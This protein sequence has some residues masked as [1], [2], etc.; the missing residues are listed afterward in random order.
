MYGLGHPNEDVAR[1]CPYPSVPRECL[2]KGS[3]LLRRLEKGSTFTKMATLF[4]GNIASLFCYVCG[5]ID[6]VYN[7]LWVC[8]QYF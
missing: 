8:S 1:G 3:S 5:W 2:D 6:D 7:V 4:I